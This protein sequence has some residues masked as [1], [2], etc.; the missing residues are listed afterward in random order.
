MNVDHRN[1]YEVCVLFSNCTQLEKLYFIVKD[2]VE[3][4][5]DELLKIISNSSLNNL[6]EFSFND[7]WNFSLKGLKE[8]FDDQ[9]VIFRP[10]LQVRAC[11]HRLSARA[12]PSLDPP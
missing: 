12:I 5:G 10:G 4:N 8:F 2:L 11:S 3:P 1:L 9:I 7:K 6:R